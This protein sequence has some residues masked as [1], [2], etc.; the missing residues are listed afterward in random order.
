MAKHDR[1]VYQFVKGRMEII[2]STVYT[3]NF[4]GPEGKVVIDPARLKEDGKY[5]YLD[6]IASPRMADGATDENIGELVQQFANDLRAHDGAEQVMSVN[7]KNTG[8][9]RLNLCVDSKG[10]PVS[11]GEYLARLLREGHT[12]AVQ[13]RLYKPLREKAVADFRASDTIPEPAKSVRARKEQAAGED[14]DSAVA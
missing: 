9:K 5:R 6:R 11:V 1:G 14:T 8:T 4:D 13:K 2:P 7:G 3:L 10:T 12:L